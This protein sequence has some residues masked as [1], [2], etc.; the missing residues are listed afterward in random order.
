VELLEE[1]KSQHRR[2]EMKKFLIVAGLLTVIATPALAQSFDPDEGTGNS[3]PFA[4]ATQATESGHPAFAQALARKN[5]TSTQSQAS[6]PWSTTIGES[7]VHGD[8]SDGY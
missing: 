6:V 5:T 4:Y 8:G 2:S 1:I 7:G 3:M